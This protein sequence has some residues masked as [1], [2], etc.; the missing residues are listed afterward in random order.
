[1]ADDAACVV[2]SI[3]AAPTRPGYVQVMV[4]GEV[5]ILDMTAFA[6]LGLKAGDRLTP[7]Q[8]TSLRFQ[9][10]LSQVKDRALR[11]L[12]F[13]ALTERELRDRLRQQDS[14]A[15]VIDQVIL[16]LRE[17]GYLD[18]RSYAVRWVQERAQGRGYGPVRLRYELLQKGVAPEYIDE[19]LALLSPEEYEQIAYDE[20][21]RRLLRRSAR[22]LTDADRRRLAGFLQRRG[23]TT[24]TVRRVLRR[25]DAEFPA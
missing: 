7:A 21:R 18:D 25:L 9:S 2:E 17:L 13:R 11:L 6:A 22:P 16:W 12:T 10:T 14:P 15:D 3:V 24:E 8:L 1:M 20:A 4:A 5:Y 23:F 19:A